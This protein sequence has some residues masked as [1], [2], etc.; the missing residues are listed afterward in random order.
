MSKV[1]EARQRYW[2]AQCKAGLTTGKLMV[3][4]HGSLSRRMVLMHVR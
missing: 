1:K 3:C 4:V 2:Q